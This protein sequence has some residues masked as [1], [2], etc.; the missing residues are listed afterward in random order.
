MGRLRSDRTR[1]L[2][3]VVAPL[4]TLAVVGAFATW[5]L[6][7]G[8]GG[9]DHLGDRGTA[10]TD[11]LDLVASALEVTPN[12]LYVGGAFTNAGG[13][14]DADRIAKWNG[15]SWSAIGPS[16]FPGFSG[17]VD[18]IAVDGNNVYVGGTFKDAGGNAD[19][20]HLAVWNGT[21]WAP[22]CTNPD[23]GPAF[24]GNVTSLQ[25]VGRSLYVGGTFIEGAGIDGSLIACDLDSGAPS[26]T[27][28]NP[29]PGPVYALAADSDGTLYA[30]GGFT[31]LENNPAA[32][33]VAFKPAGGAWQNMGA[34]GG[35]C[36]CAVTDFVR[37]LTTV[38]T[39][40]YIGTDANDVA[41]IPQADHVA[42]WNGTAW[43]AVG[44]GTGGGNGWF[45]TLGTSINALAGVGSYLFVTGTFLN[46]NGDPRAD[47]VA[48]F[49]GTDWHPVGS[50]GAG[51]GPWSGNGLALALFQQRLYATGNFTSAGGD[52]QAQSAAS[53][54][55]S[56]IIAVATPTVTAA[57]SAVA[58]PTVTP[59]PSAVATPTVTPAPA[60]DRAAPRTLL[61]RTQINHAKRKATFRFASGEA[62]SGFRCKLDKKKY[63]PCT[64]PKTY[65]KLKRGKHVFRVKARDRAGNV[66]K[67]PMVKR[68]RIK[69][70][71]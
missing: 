66:D 52:T 48:W 36:S 20:D 24:E 53:F 5:A 61:R 18:A 10:G 45:P 11:S 63:K 31:N 43:S 51:N 59:G 19:A 44:A 8:P 71:A 12:A 25:I 15:S 64:S 60:P 22:F 6:A 16:G 40:L 35:T 46:A 17:R 28:V 27:S 41:G 47:H 32:D 9:W 57:P 54:A 37:G 33:K 1:R 55:L 65:K 68:F 30:G 67:T 3:R 21:G 13:V 7:A 39:T 56:Q 38:G 58:T 34:G 26:P 14:P 50:D 42:R 62:G 49:D 23:P 29:F 69:R 2:L 4:S 70:A